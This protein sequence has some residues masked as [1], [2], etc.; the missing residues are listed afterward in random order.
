M[1]T[2]TH[3]H[4][5]PHL[6]FFLSA[7]RGQSEGSC[8]CFI[9]QIM[10]RMALV[11]LALRQYYT[12]RW[13]ANCYSNGRIVCLYFMR[14]YR[15]TRPRTGQHS[16]RHLFVC[17]HTKIIKSCSYYMCIIC[18]TIQNFCKFYNCNRICFCWN[19]VRS[20]TASFGIVKR[21]SNCCLFLFWFSLATN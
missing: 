13:P 14:W 4:T 3:T 17:A 5:Y 1:Y 2:H 8:R 18:K 20:S 15:V 16:W 9:P 11:S 19:Y 10:Y 6:F 12:V 7:H 21:C